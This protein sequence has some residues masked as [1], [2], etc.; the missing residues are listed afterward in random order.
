MMPTVDIHESIGTNVPSLD[1][2]VKERIVENLKL[3]IPPG[4]NV[5]LT[6][7]NIINFAVNRLCR[8]K[9]I[10]QID[11]PAVIGLAADVCKLWNSGFLKPQ[12]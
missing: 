6:Q 7:M 5:G 12:N 4:I 8:A 9:D 11:W 2:H 3:L 1:L 10:N